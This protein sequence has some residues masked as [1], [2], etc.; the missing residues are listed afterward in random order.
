MIKIYQL[1]IS[2]TPTIP[3]LNVTTYTTVY[4]SQIT[5]NQNMTTLGSTRSNS[6]S[7]IEYTTN[8]NQITLSVYPVSISTDPLDE[9]TTTRNGEGSTTA[10]ITSTVDEETTTADGEGSTTPSGETTP[11]P[12]SDVYCNHCIKH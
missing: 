9:E 2:A 1:Y 10:G 11:D 8:L 7:D 6:E 12:V 3:L 5:E 4:P